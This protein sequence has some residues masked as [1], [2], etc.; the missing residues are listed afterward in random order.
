MIL[1]DKMDNLEL[2]SDKKVKAI[3]LGDD[4][5]YIDLFDGLRLGRWRRARK[6]RARKSAVRAA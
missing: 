4:C 3:T 2:N 5:I 6:S 1:G